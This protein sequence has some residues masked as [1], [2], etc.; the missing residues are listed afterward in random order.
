M[1][2]F[3]EQMKKDLEKIFVRSAGPEAKTCNYK[4]VG[5]DNVATCTLTNKKCTYR[6]C[7]SN[8][9][10]DISI[11]T[12]E[13]DGRITR[14]TLN[15]SGTVSTWYFDNEEDKKAHDEIF[16][17]VFDPA[18]KSRVDGRR[19]DDCG[20]VLDFVDICESHGH[21]CLACFGEFVE[22]V[23]KARRRVEECLK[24]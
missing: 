12:L 23:S 9:R 15:P 21:H 24:K 17:T 7:P 4:Q 18:M 22:R 6:G 5:A 20:K 3:S 14:R 16:R 1:T 13:K 10:T 19:C 8:P 2:E 11:E